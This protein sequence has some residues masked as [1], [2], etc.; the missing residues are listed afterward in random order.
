MGCEKIGGLG[1]QIFETWAEFEELMKERHG[2]ETERAGT[3][4]G[5]VPM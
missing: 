1:Q 5:G 3:W 4:V 2:T